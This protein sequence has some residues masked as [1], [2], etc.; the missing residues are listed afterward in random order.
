MSQVLKLKIICGS[1]CLFQITTAASVPWQV[2]TIRTVDFGWL[3]FFSPDTLVVAGK[4]SS[5][6]VLN[7]QNHN[8]NWKKVDSGP[9]GKICVGK[10]GIGY[11]TI[12]YMVTK[13][14]GL[15]WQKLEAPP[16]TYPGSCTVSEGNLVVMAG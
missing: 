8:W 5:V 7:P 4:N 3:R 14:Y 12:P 9:L 11:G 6:G 16:P 1:L 10:K 13:N 15:T 2:D